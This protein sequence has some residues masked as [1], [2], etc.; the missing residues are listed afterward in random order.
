MPTCYVKYMDKTNE[1][2][3]ELIEYDLDEENIEWLKIINNEKIKN[4][5]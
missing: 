1:E 4:E 3:N 5:L 2:L